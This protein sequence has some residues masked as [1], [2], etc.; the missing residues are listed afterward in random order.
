MKKRKIF[1]KKKSR[2]QILLFIVLFFIISI[3]LT[4]NLFFYNNNDFFII[5]NNS[6]NFYVIPKD[7]K[8][9]KVAN[10][11][12]KVLEYNSSNKEEKKIIDREFI[13]SI[14]LYSSFD[15]NTVLKK[16]KSLIE[17]LLY[18]ENDFSVIALRHD[19][20]VD[21][22]L[23]YKNFQ[24]R[25]EANNYCSKYLSFVDNCLIVNVMNID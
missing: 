4:F 10:T 18:D 1:S 13:Y 21:Y 22:L 12:F 11:N 3:P 17:N 5:K 24:K 25:D 15:Y 23:L 20:G 7:K 9:K 14:Q 2:K 19:I 6:D 8:G 16:Y